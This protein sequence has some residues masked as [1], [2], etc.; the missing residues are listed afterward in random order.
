MPMGQYVGLL[1]EK[2]RLIQ[3][4]EVLVQLSQSSMTYSASLYE[5]LEKLGEKDGRM[6]FPYKIDNKGIK[7]MI[8]S[9]IYLENKIL[10]IYREFLIE[11][12]SHQWLE[13]ILSYIID[14][15]S[16]NLKRIQKITDKRS[17]TN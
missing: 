4:Q 13:G 5:I 14:Q 8:K 9:H 6:Q 2:L 11:C 10:D 15:K 12:K 7:K 16:K 1:S 3:L 17:I